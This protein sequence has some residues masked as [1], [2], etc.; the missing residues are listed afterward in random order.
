MNIGIHATAH[1]L[2]ESVLSFYLVG[3]GFELLSSGL[4]ASDLTC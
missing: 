4:V 3:P 1:N 2:Q